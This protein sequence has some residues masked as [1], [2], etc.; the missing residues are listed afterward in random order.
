MGHVILLGDSIFDNAVYVPGELSVSEQL[1]NRLSDDWQTTLL[2]VDGDVTIDVSDQLKKLPDDASHLIVSVGGNDALQ[3]IRILEEPARSS[4]EVLL[5]LADIQNTFRGNYSRMIESVLE[6]QLPVIVCT[7]YDQMPFPVEEAFTR[8]I[9]T[10]LSVFNDCIIREAARCGVGVLDLRLVC[11][12]ASHYSSVSPIEPS[13][14]GGEKITG[15]I[16]DILTR[17]SFTESNC[18]VFSSSN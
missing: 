18:M 7:I 13:A 1:K 3:H 8:M 17:N 15:A 14:K 4:S 12:N 9:R 5:K 6:Y 11:D 2:A 10:T 16:A